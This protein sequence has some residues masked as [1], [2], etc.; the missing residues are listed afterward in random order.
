MST[1]Q[2]W[3]SGGHEEFHC[4]HCQATYDVEYDRFP[5]R[6]SDS[7]NCT[8]CGKELKQW[9]DTY[10]PKFTLRLPQPQAIAP[11]ASALVEVEDDVVTS[12]IAALCV[13]RR[14]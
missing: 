9:N 6:D 4:P 7:A 13:F 5:T 3:K 11:E 1:V 10:V 8:V 12:G 2:T 14:S